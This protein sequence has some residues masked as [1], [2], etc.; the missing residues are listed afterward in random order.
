MERLTG[1]AATPLESVPGLG[2]GIVEKLVAAG[3]TTVEALADMTPEQL[4]AIEG[5]GPKTVEKISLAVNN[6]FASL[7]GGEIAVTQA[8]E[9]SFEADELAGE[10]AGATNDTENDAAEV[11]SSILEVAGEATEDP[12]QGEAEAAEEQEAGEEHVPS[13]GKQ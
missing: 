3:I 4:E 12:A 2:E 7:E 9:G 13:S 1:T 8:E 6:Y 5:I 10:D 11:E